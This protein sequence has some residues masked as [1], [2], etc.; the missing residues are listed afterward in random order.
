[1]VIVL[2]ESESVLQLKGL[3]PTGNLPLFTLQE[4]R[5]GIQEGAVSGGGDSGICFERRRE[6]ETVLQLKSLNPG[7]KLAVG[8]LAGGK[9]A[10][11]ET[12]SGLEPGH[13]IQSFDEAKRLDQINERMPP[14]MNTP[15]VQSPS[16]SPSSKRSSAISL[17]TVTTIHMTNSTKS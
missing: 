11:E 10:L 17:N 7:G 16:A 15:P 8:V 1:M 3:T 9:P 12:L 4:G 6:S 5:R 2:E 13:R 14:T